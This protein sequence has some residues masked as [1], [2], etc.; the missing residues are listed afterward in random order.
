MLRVVVPAVVLALGVASGLV[1]NAKSGRLPASLG[2]PPA[3]LA[4]RDFTPYLAGSTR[5]VVL[6]E[7]RVA[8]S[9]TEIV[10]VGAESGQPVPRAQ[11]FVSLD[12]GRSWNLGGVT[13][14][15]GGSP[16]PGHAARFIA[17]GSGAW[18]AIGSHSVW[19][20]TDGR[21][22]TLTSATGLPKRPGDDVTVLKRTGGGFIAA[23]A[24]MPDGNRSSPVI[25]LSAD[26]RRWTRLGAAQLHLASGRGQVRDIRLAAAAGK[27]I[28]VAGDVASGGVR[29]GLASTGLAS[30][31]LAS[32]GAAWLSADGGRRW[33][34]VTVP[35]G[36]GAGGEFSDMAATANGF[37]LVRPATV[38]GLPAADVYRSG[39]GTDWTFTATL[40]TPD[41]FSPGLM[42][43]GPAG[44]VLAGRS[45]RALTAFTSADGVR[46]RQVPA[47]GQVPAETV[48]GVAV[49][50]AGAVIAGGLPAVS[51]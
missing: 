21:A 27:L 42:N 32:T 14:A 10:A 22:W 48:S 26:G 46:W 34:T 4:G 1:V 2:Y 40:T 43:G 17:G 9:G 28:L 7:G 29:T 41:G 3:V 18:A 19:T 36:H 45:G 12:D 38:D 49:T 20:S 13:S 50:T 51:S 44:A 23:G 39:N 5:G 6:S 16:P 30:T 35:A 31:G 11:F 24:S 15:D 25:F 47:L 8:S 33:R 37:L